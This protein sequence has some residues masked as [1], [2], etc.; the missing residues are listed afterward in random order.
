MKE[1]EAAAAAAAAYVWMLWEKLDRV[2]E[3]FTL[4]YTLAHI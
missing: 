2:R 3:I 1:E 4:G